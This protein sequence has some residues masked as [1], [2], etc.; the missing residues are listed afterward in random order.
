MGG[1]SG[2]YRSDRIFK[3]YLYFEPDKFKDFLLNILHISR[4]CR[5]MAFDI[6]RR[7]HPASAKES[8]LVATRRSASGCALGLPCFLASRLAATGAVPVMSVLK[9]RLN[10][11]Y[12]RLHG[13]MNKEMEC[14]ASWGTARV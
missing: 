11:D 14:S 12:D 9:Q 5:S 8:V 3:Q 7:F 6:A 4:H 1:S 2:P 13:L 10:C